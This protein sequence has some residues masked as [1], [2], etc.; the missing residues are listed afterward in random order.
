MSEQVV[1]KGDVISV[2]MPPLLSLPARLGWKLGRSF[3]YGDGASNQP[4]EQEL[5]FIPALECGLELAG[6]YE[7]IVLDLKALFE[8]ARKP[9]GYFLLNCECGYADDADIKE[10]IFVQHPLPDTI[11]WE[12]DIQGLRSALVKEMWLTHQDGYVRLIFDRSQYVADLRRMVVE[13]QQENVALELYG[14]APNDYGF[15]E[16]LLAFDMGTPIV[17]EPI[18]PPGSHLEFKLEGEEFCWL[19]GK[20]L[21]GWP[22]HYFPCWQINRVFKKWMRFF[23]RGYAINGTGFPVQSGGFYLLGGTAYD[24]QVASSNPNHFYLLDENDRAACDAAGNELARMLQK[25]V[26]ESGNSPQVTVSYS[27]CRVSAIVTCTGTRKE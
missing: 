27:P 17:A 18:L 15:T 3:I 9:G 23:Q 7:D 4:T 10:L 1:K 16:H 2:E 8:S 11:V 25:G 19:N 24:A 26:D 13:A 6:N 22:P 20:R 12:L 14:V 5:K 21:F